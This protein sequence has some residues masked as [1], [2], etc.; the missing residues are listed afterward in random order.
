MSDTPRTNRVT[1]A[2][3]EI[4]STSVVD[5]DFART[6]ER[7]LSAAQNEV[8][9]LKEDAAR[10]AWFKANCGWERDGPSNWKWYTLV[11]FSPHGN[12]GNAAIDAARRALLDN[13]A[14]PGA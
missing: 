2:R 10:W 8:E 7:E 5:S 12:F 4:A 1:R 14:E 13:P 11:P 9:R 6:L 3:S